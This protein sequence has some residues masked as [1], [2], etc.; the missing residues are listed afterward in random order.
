MAWG[1]VPAAS[2]LRILGP[3]QVGVGM[4]STEHLPDEAG[5]R[6]PRAD[7]PATT[8]ASLRQRYHLA[9]GLVAALTVVSQ[10]VVQRSVADQAQD[11]RVLH[12]AGRLRQLCQQV[13]QTAQALARTGPGPEADDLRAQLATAL[14][15][16]QRTQQGLVTGD[17][18]LG[19][20]QHHSPEVLALLEA[21]GPPADAA[22]TALAASEPGSLEAVDAVVARF[23]FEARHRAGWT[24]WLGA[25]LLA[26]TLL[27]LALEARLIVAPASRSLQREMEARRARE[28]DLQQLFE[29]SPTA[30]LL[31]DRD[32]CIVSANQQAS[33]LLGFSWPHPEC[34]PLRD[35][36]AQGGPENQRLLER[37]ARREVLDGQEAVLHPARGPAREVLVSVR[38]VKFSGDDLLVL[39]LVDITGRKQLEKKLRIVASAFESQEGMF[40]TDAE[41]RI[42]RVNRAFCAITGYTPEE[43]LGQTPRLLRS[44]EHD[45]AF[46]ATLDRELLR[47]GAWQGE[48]WNRRKNG[49]VYPLWLTITAVHDDAGALTHYVATFVDITQRKAEAQEIERLAFRDPLTNLPNR[50]LLLDRVH[51]ALVENERHQ[52]HGALLFIDLDHFK[53]LNDTFGHDHG[54]LLLKQVAGRLVRCVRREDTVARLG[55]D[56]FVVLVEHLSSSPVTAAAQASVL[57]QKVLEALDQPYELGGR[58]H[59]ATPSIGV[60]LFSAQHESIDELMKRAD[61]AMYEAKA[62]GRNTVRFFTP[63]PHRA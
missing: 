8:P 44:G 5:E 45:D 54:D 53:L 33:V 18:E 47:V 41:R 24:R 28:E 63:G 32:L 21:S 30:L 10:V 40:I 37:L 16:W 60:T 22:V 31:V 35:C 17:A 27:V 49:D 56:E 13:S 57:A 25:A 29:A 20:P 61:L 26:L 14:A 34:G 52:T 6:G 55:G 1:R 51:Q 48:V 43:A 4:R 58:E 46:Y 2:R 50:R 62:A 42:V 59:D 23:E 11:A 3:A 9:L 19:L 39:G 12:V 36:L 15:L 38:E 7:R